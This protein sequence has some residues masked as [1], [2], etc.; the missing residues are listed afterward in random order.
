MG[1]SQPGHALLSDAP[2]QPG[3]F[4]TQS[5][6]RN[7]LGGPIH[8]PGQSEQANERQHGPHSARKTCHQNRCGQKTALVDFEPGA[9]LR[10]DRNL[11]VLKYR[12]GGREIFSMV[13][14]RPAGINSATN[15]PS[16]ATWIGST[17]AAVTSAVSVASKLGKASALAASFQIRAT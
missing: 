16:T 4:V 17:L 3:S 6:T 12:A 13:A 10:Q 7:C 5:R 14:H 2:I 9:T 8:L 1:L 15:P 11:A